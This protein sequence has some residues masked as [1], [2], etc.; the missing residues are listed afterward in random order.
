MKQLGLDYTFAYCWHVQNNPDSRSGDRRAMNSINETRRLGILPQVITVSQGWSG[1]HDEGSIWKLPP[2]DYKKL[3]EEAKAI[4]KTYP[5]AELGSRILLLDNWNEW[6][7]GHYLAPHREYGFGYLDAIREVFSSAPKDPSTCPQRHRP[8]PVRPGLQATTGNEL[9][10]KIDH[11]NC[12]YSC[13]IALSGRLGMAA[14]RPNILLITADDL[15]CQLSCYGETRFSTPR[16]D[17]LAEQ[18]C[19]SRT[20]T[21]PSRRAVPRGPPCSRPLAAPERPDRPGAPRLPHASRPE[22]AH[23]PA[24]GCRLSHGHHRQTARRTGRRFPWDWMPKQ[25]VAAKPTQDVKW[26]AQESRLLCLRP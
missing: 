2:D 19:G 11:E 1:W 16:L 15:G 5:A 24:Q 20:S 22:D 12:H 21:S 14:E 9:N 26:V 25:K 13:R 4:I 7:E 17:S 3:L 10:G 18:E 23:R 6:S 8:R